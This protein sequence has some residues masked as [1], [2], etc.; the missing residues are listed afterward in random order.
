[1]SEMATG[2]RELDERV[3]VL[4]SGFDSPIPGIRT[5][6]SLLAE[7]MKECSDDGS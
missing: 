1:M 2:L 4:E 5:F 7:K 3:Q 6:G